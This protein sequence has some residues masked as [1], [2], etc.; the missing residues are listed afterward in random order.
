MSKFLR[1]RGLKWIDCKEFDLNKH[2]SNSSEICILEVHL[3]YPEK[4]MNYTM[5]I[6]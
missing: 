3:E 5:I 1:T 2:V 6:L 4:L